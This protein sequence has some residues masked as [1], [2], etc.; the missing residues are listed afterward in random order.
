MEK[1]VEFL[2]EEFD[3]TDVYEFAPQLFLRFPEN[4]H[5]KAKIRQTL[6][7]L[8]DEG[9]LEFT[10]PGKYRHLA[11][12]NKAL[13]REVPFGLGDETTRAELAEY[14]GLAGDAPLRRGM[15]KP[16]EG[17]FQKTMFLFHDEKSNPYGDQH[18]P[19][20]IV[21]V[22][23][24]K[25]GDQEMDGFNRIL[26][27]HLDLG[28]TVHY[29]TQPRDRPGKVVYQGEVVV[30]QVDRIYRSEEG[31]SVF[32]FVLLPVQN[33]IRKESA[34]VHYGELLGQILEDEREPGYDNRQRVMG[35][36]SRI[37]RDSAFRTAILQSYRERCAVCGEPL[38]IEDR[39]ELQAAHIVGVAERGPDVIPNGLSL[40]IRHH[41]AFDNGFYTLSPEY[42]IEWL[43]KK[44][45]PHDE[46][47][48]GERIEL[49]PDEDRWP[50]PFYVGHHRDKWVQFRR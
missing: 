25:S 28:V 44:P 43:A 41:W 10:G 24:G 22:G 34:S 16:A 33:Q 30:E 6:Q 32:E 17:R 8:R 14:L 37:L 49:P 29:F 45:D 38:R 31:R 3:L 23:Q 21:Y 9:K 7:V 47:R 15:F 36:Y 46:V 2:P 4:R 5:I 27:D 48:P 26:R 20:H 18:H 19:D 42:T 40:C 1:V 11:T 39:H 50:Q 13:I 12:Q 35:K